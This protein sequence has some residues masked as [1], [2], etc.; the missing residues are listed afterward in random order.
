MIP[1]SQK[2][3]AQ[4][5]DKTPPSFGHAMH[6]YFLLDP[7]YVNLNNGSYGTPPKPVYD[8][9]IEMGLDIEKNPDHFVRQISA[10]YLAHVRS[11]IADFL[12]VK[13]DECV[14]VHN[15]SHG[16]NEIL[17][18]IEW[19][20]G[21]VIVTCNTT[22]GS[23]GKTA[24]YLSDIPPHPSIS[25]FTILYP[26]TI[27]DIVSRW[28]EHIK[29]LTEAPLAGKRIVAIIDSISSTPGILLPW[30][31]MTKICKE[32]DV[33][34]VID[35][36]HSIGQEQNIDLKEADPDFWVS[37]A[38]KWLYAKRG[39][40]VLY[41]PERNEPTLK[42]SIPTSSAYISPSKRTGPN[43]VVQHDWNGTIDFVNYF[44]IET[45]MHS[46][47][48][49]VPIL[50]S[51][52]ALA[53]RKW[54]G[55][56]EKIYA[57]CHDMALRGGERLAQILGTG[58]MDPEGVFTCHMVNVQLPLPVGFEWNTE[59]YALVVERLLD[60]Y[61]MFA[62]VYKHNDRMWVRCS[63]QIWTEI[64]DFEKLGTALLAICAEVVQKFT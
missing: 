37:N 4:F 27:D 55:G 17:R 32:F 42:S 49:N 41:V 46:H 47:Q 54:I 50:T 20:S 53:F 6:E 28:R 13:V 22:Y 11:M 7:K 1:A 48:T 15:D 58:L 25:Q 23:I 44:S 9:A 30:K 18:N 43:M 35:A 5:K 12:G 45:G 2:I 16:M 60:T 51:S 64:E 29:N 52:P 14:L 21:D 40:A 62:S 8:F 19:R 61:N 3:I 39:C 63:A 33:I 31:Q 38:H 36:A 57:Y 26:T 24:Q 59:A 34:S 10:K 56:E